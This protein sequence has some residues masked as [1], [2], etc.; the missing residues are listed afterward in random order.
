MQQLEGRPR[1]S[2]S[3]SCHSQQL[4]RDRNVWKT[5][6]VRTESEGGKVLMVRMFR[7]NGSIISIY[8]H[9][10]CMYRSPGKFELS[11]F[12]KDSKSSV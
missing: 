2:S 8:F 10:S 7:D 11:V 5:T 9:F 6:G 1:C 4:P 3:L 12:N